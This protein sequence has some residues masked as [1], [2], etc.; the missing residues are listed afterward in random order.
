MTQFRTLPP[1]ADRATLSGLKILVAEDHAVTARLIGDV[2]RAAGM[3]KVEV[4]RDGLAARQKLMVWDPDI[5][6]TDWNMPDMDGLE[7][8]RSIRAAAVKPDKRVPNPR[9]PIIMLTATRS[10]RDVEVARLAGVNEFVIKP[11]TAASVLA[12]IELVL[13]RPREFIISDVYVGPDRRRRA[14][15]GYAGPKRRAG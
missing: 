12:R 5:L 2:L 13:T 10:Q 14:G 4:A 1:K 6:F 8:T 15:D 9:V 3:P 11:F 7:L